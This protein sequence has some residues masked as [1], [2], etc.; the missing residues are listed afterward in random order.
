MALRADPPSRSTHQFAP[1]LLG[2][3]VPARSV[4]PKL[5]L[6][7]NERDQSEGRVSLRGPAAHRGAPPPCWKSDAVYMAA[8]DQMS[9]SPKRPCPSAPSIHAPSPIWHGVPSALATIRR[10]APSPLASRPLTTSIG[11]AAPCPSTMRSRSSRT[12]ATSGTGPEQ[13]GAESRAQTEVQMYFNSTNSSMPWR[14]PS[15]PSPDCLTPPKGATSVEMMPVFTPTI[16]YS[17]ASC[18]RVMRPMSRA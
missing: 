1:P 12:K 11:A 10:H 16:P 2:M 8:A 15:R 14:E 17:S 3:R 13:K 5:C 6:W 9:A 18:T 7:R 4:A